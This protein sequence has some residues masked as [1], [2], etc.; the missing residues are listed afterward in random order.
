[1]QNEF[2]GDRRKALE[3]TYFAKHNRALFERLRAASE[4]NAEL[5]PASGSAA[6]SRIKRSAA[7]GT[8]S[9]SLA[10][11]SLV[12]LVA[13]AWA[14]AGVDDKERS[15]V[16]SWAAELGLTEGDPA[17]QSLEGWLA[18]PP[19]PELL[20]AWKRDYVG[21]LSL[22]LSQEARRELKTQIL[23]R[24]RAVAHASGAFS[25]IGQTLSSAEQA[26]IEEIESAFP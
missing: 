11:L 4:A 10:A 2:L 24:A 18:E 22:A 20:A 25:G 13:M 16:L 12:P 17:Y 8:D 19:T 5:S 9:K 21:P 26:I 3:E 1:M 15:M 14:G 7:I 23:G 6:D